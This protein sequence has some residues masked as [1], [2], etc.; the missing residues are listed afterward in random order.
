MKIRAAIILA[1]SALLFSSTAFAQH[2]GRWASGHAH[3]SFNH[4]GGAHWV[5]PA[6]VAGI[7]VYALTRPHVYAAPPVT[8]IQT[9]V[10]TY[11][12][13]TYIQQESVNVPRCSAWREVEGADGII[14]RE[15]TCY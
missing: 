7:A 5:A 13:Q 4:R 3:G 11:P 1:V 8:Y 10:Y 6:V 14:T 12:Q 15:R 9:P 2:G